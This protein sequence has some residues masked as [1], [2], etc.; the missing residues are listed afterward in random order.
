MET[1]LITG[2]TGLLGRLFVKYFADLGYQVF[3]TTTSERRGEE[4]VFSA[5]KGSDVRAIVADLMSPRG[6]VDI[7]KFLK[8][9]DV[10]VNHLVNNARSM[11]S[12][13]TNQLGLTE[14][15]DFA[16]ELMLDVIIPYELS[17]GIGSSNRGSLKTITNI[18]SI[19]GIVATN[20]SLYDASVQQ[21]PIQYSVAKAALI[22]L[23]KELSVRMAS[24]FVRVNCIAYGGVQGRVND[25]FKSRYA[26]LCPAG[27][28][29]SGEDIVGP[30]SFF[31]DDAS[32]GCN[33][34]TLVVDGGWSIW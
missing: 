15:D 30:L 13:N 10:S 33:G 7:V 24:D 32:S 23:T 31:V 18:S 9:E 1:I 27:R 14:R 12:L 25:D 34:H 11:S 5:R 19:Y 21:S 8:E 17:I 28:M 2:G 29:L 16:S 22:H 4:L 26:Q 20:P 6:V 3:F